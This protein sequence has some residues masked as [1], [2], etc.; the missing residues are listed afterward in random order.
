MDKEL[1]APAAAIT[2]EVLRQTQ[3]KYGD[4]DEAVIASAFAAAYR[5]LRDGVKEVRKDDPP[6][7]VATLRI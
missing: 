6:P 3:A 4:I 5:G 7:T 2:V 1:I